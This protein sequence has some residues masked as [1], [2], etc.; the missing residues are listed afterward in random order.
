[1]PGVFYGTQPEQASIVSQYVA[2]ALRRRYIIMGV[3]AGCILIGLIG[4]L[5]MTPKYTAVTTVEIS[6]ESDKVTGFQG[7][8]RE[9]S[10]ADQEF[11]QTQYGLLEARSLSE[12]VAGQLRLIDDPK[13]FE[14]FRF[15]SKN[16][17]F[18]VVDG[19]YSAAGRALRQREAGNILRDHVDIAPTRLSRLVDIR[20]TSPSAEFSA[21]VANAW[22]ENFI[23][24]NLERKVQATSY[25]RNLLQQQLTQ[26]KER[27]DQSQRQLVAYA[28]EQ[29]IIN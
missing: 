17:A 23:Q 1:M 21:K 5:L 24:I 22:A 15:S 26:F 8:E 25:G 9:V 20:F 2:I 12:R 27:L 14:L 28:S 11:Y 29:Q 10:V 4:T 7:V 16:S 13:F 3:I 18:T 6:R 19:R